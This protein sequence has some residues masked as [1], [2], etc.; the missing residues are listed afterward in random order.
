MI[1]I[2]VLVVWFLFS[3]EHSSVERIKY[4]TKPPLNIVFK[5]IYPK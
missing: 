1:E 2:F 5:P 3:N 4:L